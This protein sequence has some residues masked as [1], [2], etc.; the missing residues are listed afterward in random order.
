M[1][2]RTF[3]LIRKEFIHI[4]RDPRTLAIMIITAVVTGIFGLGA[5]GAGALLSNFGG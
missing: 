2:L 5:A 4:V 3:S 1:F